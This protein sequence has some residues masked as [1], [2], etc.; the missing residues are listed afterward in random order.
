MQ[1]KSGEVTK[2][3][4]IPANTNTGDII[5]TDRADWQ[6]VTN[7]LS[8]ATLKRGFEWT[9]ELTEVMKTVQKHNRA[10]RQSPNNA[11]DHTLQ[12]RW[13]ICPPSA[14]AQEDPHLDYFG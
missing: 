8:G 14:A 13:Q 11:T 3:T 10:V 5:S 9:E 4:V 2:L 12:E 6:D 1:Y 7:V